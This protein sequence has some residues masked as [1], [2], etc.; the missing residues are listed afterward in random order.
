MK[1]V[2]EED[3]F[4]YE[5][6]IL[7]LQTSIK[8]NEY[9]IKSK[10]LEIDDLNKN[11]HDNKVKSEIDGIVKTINKETPSEM[12]QSDS[13]FI[14]IMAVGDYRIKGT[15]NEQNVRYLSEGDIVTVHSR[16][17]DSIT[18]S[19]SI[20]TID[21]D[22][23]EEGSAQGEEYYGDDSGNS[24]STDYSF[25]VELDSAEGLMMG[26]HVYIEIG[27]STTDQEIKMSLY[28]GYILQEDGTSYVWA[29]NEDGRLE[30]RTVT[31]GVFDEDF[32]SYVIVDGLTPEDYIAWPDAA[33]K[34][35]MPVTTNPSEAMVPS[36]GDLSEGDMTDSS[37]EGDESLDGS[38]EGDESLD[39]SYEG[40]ESLDG[41][42]EG[43]ESLD[44]SYEGDESLGGSYEGDESLDGSYE[45]DESLDESGEEIIKKNAEAVRNDLM[46]EE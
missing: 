18:W 27:D 40:D 20:D 33:L 17:D 42:Y 45:G 21:T 5:Y 43:D 31:L 2:K 37:Y 6:Q 29:E 13:G 46:T 28:Q 41:S 44:G 22:H 26:Q 4:Q 32:E 35:G 7:Q 1:K 39:G 34:E 38:Y 3:K 8:K 10:K 19:G 12:E 15:V 25:Y 11:I 16:V 30:K 23:A 14:T 9:E 36:E 24:G